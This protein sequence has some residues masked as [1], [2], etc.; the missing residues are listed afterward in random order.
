MLFRS[1][2]VSSST[3]RKASAKSRFMKIC[4]VRRICISHAKPFIVCKMSKRISSS[5]SFKVTIPSKFCIVEDPD[6]VLF[7]VT[8]LGDCWNLVNVENWGGFC[9]FFKQKLHVMKSLI[10]LHMVAVKI[11]STQVTPIKFQRLAVSINVNF[12]TKLHSA[13]CRL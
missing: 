6:I 7:L 1:L 2:H 10:Y 4:R 13:L 3:V 12:A 11:L 5:S 9:F 8:L